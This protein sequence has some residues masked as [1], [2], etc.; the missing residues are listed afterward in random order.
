LGR[1]GLQT[2]E[3]SIEMPSIGQ[4]DR[5]H[6]LIEQYRDAGMPLIE[7]M[8]A[9]VHDVDAEDAA[10]REVADRARVVPKNART[11]NDSQMDLMC[12]GETA[13][14][15]YELRCAEIERQHRGK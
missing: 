2:E 8:Q 12:R 10:V 14:L 1:S 15:A 13:R 11:M 6:R 4:S 5:T 3:G 9:A 7:A